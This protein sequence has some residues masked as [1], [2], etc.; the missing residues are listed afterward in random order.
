MM[1]VT[2][3]P[4]EESITASVLYNK[5]YRDETGNDLYLENEWSG[6]VI[7]V[8]GKVVN[9]GKGRKGWIDDYANV[10][11]AWGAWIKEGKQPDEYISVTLQVDTIDKR[12]KMKAEGVVVNLNF[13]KKHIR[14]LIVLEPGEMFRKG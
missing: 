12:F 9:V 11:T 13:D 6:K 14:D 8:T 5:F 2:N 3:V 10:N 1:M 4:A 7:E